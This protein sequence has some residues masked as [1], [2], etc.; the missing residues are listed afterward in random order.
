MDLEERSRTDAASQFA[1][2]L[3]RVSAPKRFTLGVLLVHG[4]GTQ[5]SGD[6]LVR[7]GETL[8]KIIRS[9]TGNR[10][11]VAVDRGSLG[12]QSSDAPAQVEVRLSTDDHAERWLL[13]E[14]W[15]AESFRPP[16]YRELVSW[17]ARAL[18]W[19]VA[20]HVAARYWRAAPRKSSGAKHLAL[21]IAFGQL[22]VALV[23]TPVF[24][25]FLA[26]I[27]VLGLIPIPQVRSL[28]LSAQSR[29]TVTV[30]D[31]LAFV[32]SPVRAA[33][34]RTRIL[35]GLERLRRVCDHTVVVAHS[36]G[37]AAAL[38]A[39]GGIAD[40]VYIGRAPADSPQ[41]SSRVPDTLVTFGAGTNQLVSLKVLFGGL[42]QKI[43]AN[44]PY[45]AVKALLGAGGVSVFFYAGVQTQLIDV[46]HLL[47][48]VALFLVVMGLVLLLIAIG[49][50]VTKLIKRWETAGKRVER[51]KAWTARGL[52]LGM[53]AF[54]LVCYHYYGLDLFE[55]VAFLAMMVSILVVAVWWLADS[56]RLILS[57][58]M[59]TAVSAPVG[60]PPGL[61]RWVDIYASA[62]PV[63]HGP[64]RIG[65]SGV[66]ESVPIWNRGSLLSDHTSYWDNLD[67]FVLRVVRVCA[68]TAGSPWQATLPAETTCVDDRAAWRVSFLRLARWVT[69][70]VWLSLFVLVWRRYGERIPL[71]FDVL[72]WLP[73]WTQSAVRFTVLAALISLGAL[74]IS[75]V[76]RWPWTLWVRAEQ[77]LILAHDH[78][79]GMAPDRLIWMSTV[80]WMLVS[81]AAVIG[82]RPALPDTTTEWSAWLIFG[83]VTV[84]GWSLISTSVLRL[85]LPPPSTS[86]ASDRQPDAKRGEP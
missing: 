85:L 50:C 19:S 56:L 73:V 54:V 51:I 28:I 66:L 22:L 53:V 83:A 17:S 42:P 29:L 77:E 26:L 8:L 25:V 81:V 76:L 4:I 72:S 39:L 9:A 23:F 47:S 5:S 32:E 80:V 84:Y 2:G 46:W 82:L 58:D 40:P 67:G 1:D 20:I 10:V 71:P 33:L 70:S 38:D 13:A 74:L 44:P 15:W 30:G 36:Q 43:G 18:P 59:E 61:A 63:P 57:K 75:A 41:A 48:A 86:V 37:A 34:I 14:G 24:I 27:I 64:T 6:T 60:T 45:R 78:P 79:T 62:D 21:A 11:V 68:Q 52:A 69:G 3:Q 7:W 55:E 31:S 49:P 65:T 35:D 12:G 16:S